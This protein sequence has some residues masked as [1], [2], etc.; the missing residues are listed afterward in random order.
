MG[1]FNNNYKGRGKGHGG[2]LGEVLEALNARLGK[3]ASGRRGDA[4]K[5]SSGEQASQAFGRD[6]PA[7]VERR[8]R[9]PRFGTAVAL[10]L[11]VL[12]SLFAWVGYGL[13]DSILAWASANVGA[14]VETGKDAA[15]ATGIG[16]EVVGAFD[17]S[18]TTGFLGG[19]VGLVGVVLRPLIVVVWLG[20]AVLILAAPWLVSLLRRKFRT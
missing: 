17:S 2:Q 11:L 8:S 20:G 14:I 7:K 9:M 16:T 13:V 19:L 10:T 15:A 18:Q 4:E 12:W 5:R 3:A 1:D 6:G